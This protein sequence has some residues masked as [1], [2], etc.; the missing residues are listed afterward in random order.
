MSQ[1]AVRKTR[2]QLSARISNGP[3]RGPRTAGCR[4]GLVLPSQRQ[5]R[6]S[7]RH[8]HDAQRDRLCGEQTR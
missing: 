7:E 1:P 2:D 5:Q 8:V 4:V 3:G 6:T